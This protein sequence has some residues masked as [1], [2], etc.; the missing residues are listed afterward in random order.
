MNNWLYNYLGTINNV[1]WSI[2]IL[3]TSILLLVYIRIKYST[4]DMSLTSIRCLSNNSNINNI[5]TDNINTDNINNELSTLFNKNPN[6]LIYVSSVNMYKDEHSNN[7]P[8]TDLSHIED[9]AANVNLSNIIEHEPNIS[10]SNTDNKCSCLLDNSSV[11]SDVHEIPTSEQIDAN[12]ISH[13]YADY[14]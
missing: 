14:Y 11:I 8:N 13:K 12:Y 9:V 10:K 3:G 5:N 6:I 1:P 7:I 4:P 2:V